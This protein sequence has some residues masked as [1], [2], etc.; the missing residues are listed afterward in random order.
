MSTLYWW[1]KRLREEG[2]EGVGTKGRRHLRVRRPK[3]GPEL[4]GAVL[5]KRE[6]HPTWGKDKLVILA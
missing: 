2:L 4:A 3:W 5:E 6:R 1:D